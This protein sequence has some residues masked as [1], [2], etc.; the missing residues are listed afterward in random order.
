MISIGQFFATIGC[1]IALSIL[2]FF[3]LTEGIRPEN[4]ASDPMSFSLLYS[5][6]LAFILVNILIIAIAAMKVEVP[7]KKE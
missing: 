1:S 6:R 4:G 5:T 2:S 7:S 3:I